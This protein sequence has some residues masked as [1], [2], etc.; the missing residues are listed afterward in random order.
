MILLAHGRG[1]SMAKNTSDEI[2][3]NKKGNQALLIKKF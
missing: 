2:Q 3:F 1:L